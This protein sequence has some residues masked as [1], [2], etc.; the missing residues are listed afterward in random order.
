MVRPFRDGT[1]T[2]PTCPCSVDEIMNMC[3]SYL[4]K[5]YSKL[6]RA[7]PCRYTRIVECLSCNRVSFN[8]F[9]GKTLVIWWSHH[10]GTGL[11]YNILCSAFVPSLEQS[12]HNKSND[13]HDNIRFDYFRRK[14]KHFVPRGDHTPLRFVTTCDYGI[15]NGGI[16][17]HLSILSSRPICRY[18]ATL[19]FFSTLYLFVII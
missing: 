19:T 5:A 18:K 9:L 16:F 12:Q 6:S 3:E 2:Y 4:N 13:P 14:L 7:S 15:F 8:W 1:K 17:M 10:V 11:K